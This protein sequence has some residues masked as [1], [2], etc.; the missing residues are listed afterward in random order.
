MIEQSLN[1]LKLRGVFASTIIDKVLSGFLCGD[2][3]A[4]KMLNGLV[5]SDL[6]LEANRFG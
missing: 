3:G 4:N 1:R 5:S 2:K 6:A